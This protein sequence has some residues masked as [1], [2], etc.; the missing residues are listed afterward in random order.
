MRDLREWQALAR[1]PG[2]QCCIAIMELD[3]IRQIVETHGDSASARMIVSAVNIVAAN[4]RLTDRVFRYDTGKVLIRLSGT[5]LASGKKLLMRLR[6]T[7][8]RTGSPR[9][10]A[11]GMDTPVTASFGVAL[12]D[13]EVD[14]LESI[15]RADQALTLAKTAGRNRV[16]AWSRRS[17]RRAVAADRG[18]DVEG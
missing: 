1:Q 16:I 13:P 4:L 11:E 2:R 7:V 8:A 18:Q 5:D 9:I 3:G 15:D 17:Q 10:A 14:V 12:L 6:E